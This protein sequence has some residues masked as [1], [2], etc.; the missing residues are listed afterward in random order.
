MQIGSL[1]NSAGKL[2]SLRKKQTPFK[3]F[4]SCVT[5]WALRHRGLTLCRLP[6]AIGAASRP[7]GELSA[8]SWVPSVPMSRLGWGSG[9]QAGEQ[10]FFVVPLEE[11]L[12]HSFFW[13]LSIN[14]RGS[15]GQAT[16]RRL[17]LSTA[18][19]EKVFDSGP[20]L[21]NQ[22]LFSSSKETRSYSWNLHKPPKPLVH[23]AA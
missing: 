3:R 16:S 18:P 19:K 9:A 1:A 2:R 8:A 5:P 6:E 12:S 23:H 21:A 10:A 15:H 22:V 11:Q 14:Q 20:H 7:R 4:G 17:Q 13:A